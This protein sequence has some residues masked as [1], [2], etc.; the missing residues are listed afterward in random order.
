MYAFGGIWLLP[1]IGPFEVHGHIFDRY[2]VLRST[3]GPL[4]FPIANEAGVADGR[5]SRFERGSIWWMWATGALDTQGPIDDVY[6]IFGGPNG[7]H[8]WPVAGPAPTPD[9]AGVVSRFERGAI[10]FGPGVGAFEVHGPIHDRYDQLGA[11]GGRLG[12]PITHVTVATGTSTRY[13]R[14]QRGSIWSDATFGVRALIG[15][16][17]AKYWQIGGPLSEIGLPTGEQVAGDRGGRSS[18]F[19][20][21]TITYLAP[22]GPGAVYGPIFDRYVVEG[23]TGGRLGYPTR[24]V[25]EAGPDLRACDFEHGRLTLRVST[26]VVTVS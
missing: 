11:A 24:S 5:F 18:P 21:G 26:G 1:A 10:Y 3:D 23:H 8:G 13:N 25:Y 9:G 2:R 15:G 17:D 12:Y 4:G 6:R 19:T 16:I 14:F 22:Y 20:R 7:V